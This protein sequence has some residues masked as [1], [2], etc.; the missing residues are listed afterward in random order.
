MSVE[1][2][3]TFEVDTITVNTKE[4]KASH[5]PQ[6]SVF[7]ILTSL[8]EARPS[9][10]HRHSYCLDPNARCADQSVMRG[11]FEDF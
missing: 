5:L 3:L 11:G 4:S 1:V 10:K 8:L 2:L 9:E 6:L 7:A